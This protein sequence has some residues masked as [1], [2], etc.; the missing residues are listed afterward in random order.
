M[1]G[2]DP[3]TRFSPEITS[4]I[5]NTLPENSYISVAVAEIEECDDKENKYQLVLV[6]NEGDDKEALMKEPIPE[7]YEEKLRV[8]F[9]ILTGPGV[10][11]RH[12]TVYV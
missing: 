12:D 2:Y 11:K 5:V 7:K 9:K 3:K 1:F 8:A 10:Y 6:T 4:D